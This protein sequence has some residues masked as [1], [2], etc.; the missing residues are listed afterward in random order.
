MSK[1][2]RSRRNPSYKVHR[3]VIL[4]SGGLF[5]R[6][7]F[8]KGKKR[9]SSSSILFPKATRLNPFRR[10]RRSRRARFNPGLNIKK[11]FGMQNLMYL[12]SI[13]GGVVA[14][15]LG[16]PMLD[17]FMPQAIRDQSKWAY[18]V[19][20]ILAGTMLASMLKGRALKTASITLAGM[21]IY[22]L[23]QQ[24]LVQDL[25]MISRSSLIID[26]M[27]PESGA[28]GGAGGAA[29]SEAAAAN[30]LPYGTGY[31]Q[32]AANYQAVG[33]DDP[34]QGLWQ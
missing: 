22:D 1:R 31:A 30:Y 16:I 26:K 32:L 2:R 23:I 20:Y 29:A 10:H 6:P 33:T 21:G 25:P 12:S 34:Y 8:K 13:G 4:S 18:G 15:F 28:G 11:A 24:N 19:I 14:G 9:G 7:K 27:I 5:Y 17:R 3:P